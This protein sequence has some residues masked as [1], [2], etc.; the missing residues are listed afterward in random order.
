[1][2][3]GGPSNQRNRKS[4]RKKG[5]GQ[6][7]RC[8][9]QKPIPSGLSKIFQQG[10]ED[11]GG[12]KRKKTQILFRILPAVFG[13]RIWERKPHTPKDCGSFL[14]LRVTKRLSK[15]EREEEIDPEARA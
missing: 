2:G 5:L 13:S 10:G 11:G 9:G 12:T 7:R 15:E 8:G 1:L 3:G 4:R 14:R 6:K